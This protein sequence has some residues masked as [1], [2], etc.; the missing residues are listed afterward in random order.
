MQSHTVR[1]CLLMLV[2]GGVTL[3][4]GARRDVLVSSVF[5]GQNPTENLPDCT[6]VG[7]AVRIDSKSWPVGGHYQCPSNG[8]SGNMAANP[9]PLVASGMLAC[10]FFA[11]ICPPIFGSPGSGSDMEGAFAQVSITERSISGSAVCVNSTP[12][13][14]KART[15]N[16]YD[17]SSLCNPEEE[18]DCD[19]C[20]FSANDPAQF[21]EDGG[22]FIEECSCCVDPWSPILIDVAGDGF[23]LTD[24]I[25][26]VLFD[27]DSDGVPEQLPWTSSR[28]D[29]AWLV[30]DR[31]GT[32]T[33]DHGGELFGNHT[34]Q[35]AFASQNGFLA[36][37][38]FDN[39]DSGG[40]EDG[41]IDRED[42]I[43]SE[44]RLWR[45]TN[46]DGISQPHELRRLSGVG[47]KR[48]SL[49]YRESRR[50]D[51]FGN[52]FRFRAKVVDA[53]RTDVG[54]WAFDVY[55]S[56]KPQGVGGR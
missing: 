14:V 30:L 2:I 45:D 4:S 3:Q 50:V 17:T 7:P 41:W 15:A 35:P 6:E 48:L 40:N 8:P 36:L 24:R 19:S 29:D 38:V 49:D 18:P 42:A 12:T 47:I 31:D 23:D 46:H 54:K 51:K 52:W 5:W 56:G 1:Y 11:R 20:T 53:E 37:R 39:S 10:A 34:D 28:S 32:G 9:N 25:G 16:V 13:Y 43:F 22:Y 44:L 27:L 55:L 33:I 21:S 26:G